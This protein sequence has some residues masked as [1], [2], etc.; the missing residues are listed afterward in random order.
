MKGVIDEMIGNLTIPIINEDYIWSFIDEDLEEQYESPIYSKTIQPPTTVLVDS[1]YQDLDATWENPEKISELGPEKDFYRYTPSGEFNYLAHYLYGQKDNV[2]IEPEV[3]SFTPE[4]EQLFQEFVEDN[5][6]DDHLALS[7]NIPLQNE[8]IIDSNVNGNNNESEENRED[9]YASQMERIEWQGMLASVLTGEVIE[10]EKNR[11]YKTINAHQHENDHYQRWL[12]IRA[13]LNKHTLVEE[14]LYLEKERF[15]VDLIIDEVINFRYDPEKS[16]EM[17]Q[18]TILLDQVYWIESLY[19]SRKVM[20]REKP[21]YGSEEF[22]YNLDALISWCT[23]S[24]SLDTQLTILKNWTGSETL[25]IDGST[26]I[27]GEN[28]ETSSFVEKIL[29]EDTLQR[30][31]EKKTL[32]NLRTLLTVYHKINLSR[33][34]SVVELLVI[35]PTTLIVEFLKL[36][37]KY[38]NKIV[39][40]TI[41]IVDQLLDDFKSSIS[42]ACSVKE[43]YDFISKPAPGWHM[44]LKID[45]DFDSLLFSCLKFYFKLLHWKVKLGS[46]SSNLK[47]V[48]FLESEWNFISGLI[49][50]IDRSEQEVAEQFCSL[51]LRML[52]KSNLSIGAQIK[53]QSLPNKVKS[54]TRLFESF[55]LQIRKK[56][57]FVSIL[58]ARFENSSE[59]AFDGAKSLSEVI[60]LLAKDHIL[61]NPL[62]PGLKGVYFFLSLTLANNPDQ[63]SSILNSGF[64]KED[65]V[66]HNDSGYIL[67]VSTKE[68]INWEGQSIDLAFHPPFMDLKPNRVRLVSD[69]ASTLS[70]NKY[71]FQ[72][73]FGDLG[74]IICHPKRANLPRIHRELS[75]IKRMCFKISKAI[76][77]SVAKVRSATENYSVDLIENC[78]LF[79]SEFGQRMIK[80]MDI[81]MRAK[82]TLKLIRL[83]IDWVSFVFNDCV[84]TDRK[85][86]RWV[87][88][89]LEFTMLMTSGNNIVL[90][91]ESDFDELRE[92][93][94]GCMTLLISHFDI[95]GARGAQ[96]DMFN[97]VHTPNNIS[98]DPYCSKP[99]EYYYST[100]RPEVIEKLN[101]VEEKFTERQISIGIAGRVLDSERPEDRTL[102]YLASLSNNLSIRWQQGKFLGAGTF[103]T[104]YLAINLDSGDLMAVKEFRFPDP[105]Q[106]LSLYKSI[107]EEM[108]VMKM[109]HHPNIINYYGIE[110]HRDRVFIFMEYCQN[111]SLG[112]LLEHGRI[113][114]ESIVKIYTLQML[115]GLEYLHS[116]NVLHRDIKPDNILLD[117]AGVIKFVDFGAS[118]VIAQ[119]KTLAKTT[120]AGVN[121]SLT[122]TPMYMAPEVITGGD[123]GKKGAQDIWSLGCCI[124]EM[125]TGKRPWHNL[126]NEW[127]IM[128]HIA[129]GHPPLPDTSQISPSGMDFLKKCFITQ[130]QHRPTAKQLLEHGWFD[131]LFN[132]NQN[133]KYTADAFQFKVHIN[134]TPNR[135]H[136][137]TP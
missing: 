77:D 94:A 31:L 29:K 24:E 133:I 46:K 25:Q 5:E 30:T 56:T 32:K 2:N 10:S 52:G 26:N 105:S 86:F 20:I 54:Y 76:I 102:A 129:S 51:T 37:L 58:M 35:F 110:V 106:L 38:A 41:A 43:E 4:S 80:T 13:A 135:E 14:K 45:A 100:A 3:I 65:E 119:N 87:V 131:N 27:N 9:I 71:K 88:I 17:T 83:A 75:K 21:R 60:S 82:L 128:Y 93:V 7:F 137:Y 98:F 121:K 50:K 85:T 18:V 12:G 15:C 62:N 28:T 1:S 8:S 124:L 70:M 126:D 34:I 118:K 108:S 55:R 67:V 48:E 111:G 73:L 114:D 44:R 66:D 11:I 36:R 130:P 72:N 57:K 53:D 97:S 79:A 61:I 68:K 96:E 109:L 122:G 69:S 49:Y 134:I 39:T 123:K 117:H 63:V 92:N 112:N 42:L 103:G 90:L 64:Q 19:P 78:F 22:N 132:I 91:S 113:E 74:L 99:R 59:Y 104:V 84:P 16:C 89:A 125:V 136:L 95:Q 115:Q 81:P 107:N 120:K 40:P 33:K 6:D 23:I 127:A 47:E 101:K 116:Q